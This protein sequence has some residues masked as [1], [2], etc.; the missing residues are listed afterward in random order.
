MTKKTAASLPPFH[1]CHSPELA[2]GNRPC[3]QSGDQGSAIFRRPMQ[4]AIE[5]A[6]IDFHRLGRLRREIRRQRR[7]DILGPEHAIA[8][9]GDSLS[10]SYYLILTALLSLFALMAI[11]SRGRRVTQPL[12]RPAELAAP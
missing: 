3:R 10:P 6:G 4:I 8:A 11:Q 5:I 2:G 9:T 7:L 1:Q 12:A